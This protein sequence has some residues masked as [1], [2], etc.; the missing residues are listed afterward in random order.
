M[1]FRG[2]P[3]IVCSENRAAIHG[4][5]GKCELYPNLVYRLFKADYILLRL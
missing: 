3:H 4:S 5:R 1:T 2:H